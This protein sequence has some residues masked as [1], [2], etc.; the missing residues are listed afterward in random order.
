MFYE[1]NDY[2][3]SVLLKKHALPIACIVLSII[4][5]YARSINFGLIYL[6]DNVLVLDYSWYFGN[7]SN[8]KSVLLSH[9]FISELFY[10]PVLDLSFMFNAFFAGS[11]PAIYHITNIL[12]HVFNACLVYVLLNVLSY[13]RS[14]AL[15]FAMIF[16]LHPVFSMAVAWIPGRTETILGSFVLLSFLGFLLYRM[17]NVRW[18]LVLHVVCMA[19]ALLSKET[20]I[21]LPVACGLYVLLFERAQRLSIIF[22]L[23]LYWAPVISFWWFM[24]H[25]ALAGTVTIPMRA[26]MD[27]IVKNLPALISYFGKIF[28]FGNLSVLPFLNDI[29]NIFGFLALSLLGLLLVLSKSVRWGRVIFGIAWFLAFLLPSLLLSFIAHEY[30]LY[31][32]MIGVFFV[33]GEIDFFQ[34][35]A[36]RKNYFLALN[37][38]VCGILAWNTWSRSNLLRDKRVFWESAVESSPHSPLAHRNLGAMY[39]LDNNFDAAKSEFEKTL[40]LNPSEMMVQNNLGVIYMRKQ[41]YQDAEKKFLA[42]LAV[43]PNYANAHFN[44]GVLYFKMSRYS[45]GEDQLRQTIDLDPRF[46]DAYKNL[47][48][49]YS[50]KNDRSNFDFY[51]KRAIENG[52]SFIDN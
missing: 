27:S 50:D 35:L 26:G 8:L 42:E 49:Y 48:N 31:I 16:A 13:S 6:D 39:L 41:E 25:H 46:S 30:R 10:R 11:D 19:F 9:N 2:G 24:R 1:K 20:A 28:Y 36:S 29:N 44:L 37:L 38:V 23:S 14:V 45:D 22:K 40:V 7:L 34:Y 43:Y 17:S 47:L 4:A 15:S 18:A 21:V 3:F 51:Y 5:L 52:V 33:L 12:I 32:S